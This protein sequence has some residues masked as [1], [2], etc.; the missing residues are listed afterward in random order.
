MKRISKPLTY[1]EKEFPKVWLG[2]VVCT[3]VFVLFFG[4]NKAIGIFFGL[5]M[6]IFGSYFFK[7]TVWNVADEVI[8]YG[9]YLLFRKAGIEQKVY[10]TDI[11]EIDC[12]QMNMPEIVVVSTSVSGDI[13]AKLTFKVKDS[14]IPFR[15]SKI[16]RELRQR[17]VTSMMS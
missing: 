9:D 16:T 12:F 5:Q 4:E 14:W 10:F 7:K 11:S 13:G 6:A 2:F 3:V 1:L 17:V 15:Y 8:D